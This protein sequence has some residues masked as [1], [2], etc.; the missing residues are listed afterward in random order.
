MPH[1]LSLALVTAL[2]APADER[3]AEAAA[4]RVLEKA[5]AVVIPRAGGRVR[6]VHL[7]SGAISEK[8][9]AVLADCK[10]LASLK[11]DRT[12]IR[13]AWLKY[14]AGLKNL[15]N[16]EIN[17]VPLDADGLQAIARIQCLLT[18]D[19]YNCGITDAN[20][21]ALASLKSL[22]E[23]HLDHSPLT[24]KS[25]PALRKMARLYKLD[26]YAT[27]ITPAGVK[28]LRDGRA[29]LAVASA[30]L[31]ATGPEAR[32]PR[33]AREITKAGGAVFYE[34][35]KF[36][37]GSPV[38]SITF[39]GNLAPEALVWLRDLPETK[40]LYLPH[41]Y[42]RMTDAQFAHITA[43][44]RLEQLDLRNCRNITAAGIRSLKRLPHLRALYLG[45]TRVG[46][47]VWQ[48]VSEMPA[49][50]SLSLI[51][52][53][54]AGKGLGA[55]KKNK[56]LA[57]LH[58]GHTLLTDQALL[59]LTGHTTL[60]T[61]NLEHT[62]ITAAGLAKLKLPKLRALGLAGS[63]A[64][65]ACLACLKG[66]PQLTSLDLAGTDVSDDALDAVARDARRLTHLNLAGTAVTDAGL[67][68]LAGLSALS[69]LDL[70]NTLTGDAGLKPLRNLPLHYLRLSGTR[71]TDAGLAH[72]ADL[73]LNELDL[74]DTRVTSEGLAKLG[75]KAF[76]YSLD[77]SH[78]EAAARLPEQLK[79][80]PSL[81]RLH[82]AR[83]NLT[84]ALEK[85]IR[86]A[87]P[88]LTITR[89]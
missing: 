17:S 62:A 84:P 21:E 50:S 35:G 16:L 39:N 11:L 20:V 47:D 33:A 45:G 1:V 28:T 26:L 77:L 69:S 12:P 79:L 83:V 14:L 74:S 13:P 41:N 31:P 37:P 42:V 43:A 46:D 63:T 86:E 51:H 18:L 64:D 53:E 32:R 60:E 9:F 24:D 25:V 36:A 23:L 48:A 19:L 58:L 29:S 4:R 59:S 34:P 68:R 57:H 56:M 5:N 30:A 6:F 89:N 78:T 85:S 52:V 38:H 66:M 67:S 3:P 22:G 76:L 8:D 40:N 88:K 72:L 15:I 27:S 82:L 7:G 49:L 44:Q 73:W 87:A 65:D 75:G 71:L 61:L 81:T 70:S 2:A 55:L 80:W 10:S 54:V